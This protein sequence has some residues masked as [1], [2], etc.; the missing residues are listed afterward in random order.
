MKKTGQHAFVNQALVCL[1]VT[2][3]FGGS[4]GLGTV[5]MRHQISQTANANRVLKAQIV[6]IERRL[7]EM[8]TLIESEQ[9]PE[10]LRQRNADMRIG[11]MPVH[12]QQMVH[13]TEDPVRRLIERANRELLVEPSAAAV[14]FR[15]ALGP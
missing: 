10:L 2:I 9:S 5:W 7:S 6:E 15:V 8:T 11:L 1:L 4:V 13:V 3:G 12:E 14:T